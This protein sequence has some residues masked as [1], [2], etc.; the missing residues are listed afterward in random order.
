[1]KTCS[2]AV[3]LI[4]HA[5]QGDAHGNLELVASL[6][7]RR[8]GLYRNTAVVFEVD[9]TL[10][11]RCRKMHIP[12]NPGFHE[13]FYFT[14][15]DLG[16]TPVETSL[17]RLRVLVWRDQWYP[18]ASAARRRSLARSGTATDC[19]PPILGKGAASKITA[20]AAYF[21]IEMSRGV[22]G[23]GKHSGF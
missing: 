20:K 5:D 3:A 7:E 23:M 6:F 18:E 16:F 14:P 19:G 11:A 2:F 9:G 17:G 21:E 13:K 4:Q 8:A 22:R 10:L 15:G 1:M 12:D